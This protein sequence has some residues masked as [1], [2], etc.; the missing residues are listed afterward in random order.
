MNL[1]FRQ[2]IPAVLRVMALV[3]LPWCRGSPIFHR[4]TMPLLLGEGTLSC[5][6]SGPHVRLAIQARDCYL[7]MIPRAYALTKLQLSTPPPTGGR[8]A[9]E[10]VLPSA[11]TTRSG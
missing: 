6:L 2:I 9:P 10:I 8:P 3:P 1:P 4:L 11:P 5:I 7:F